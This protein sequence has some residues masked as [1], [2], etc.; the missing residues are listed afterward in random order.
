MGNHIAGYAMADTAVALGAVRARTGL[1]AQDILDIVCTPYRGVDVSFSGEDA[2]SNSPFG[3]LITEAFAPDGA[4]PEGPRTLARIVVRSVAIDDRRRDSAVLGSQALP[5]RL[6]SRSPHHERQVLPDSVA[7]DLIPHGDDPSSHSSAPRISASFVRRRS[8]CP[9]AP[10]SHLQKMRQCRTFIMRVFTTRTYERAV[11][12]LLPEADRW[13]MEAAIVADPGCCACYPGHRRASQ[14]ALG[15]LGTGKA[16]WDPHDLFPSCRP[17]R[18][19]SAYRI[20]EGGP[21]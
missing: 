9:Q 17:R 19:L 13:A 18:D 20:C 7:V 16:G 15:G 21:G 14:A 4:A 6:P 3:K 10:Q 1:T 12:K 11:R 5:S 8:A 2:D